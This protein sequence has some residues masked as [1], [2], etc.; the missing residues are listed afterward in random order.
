MRKIVQTVYN[1]ALTHRH[2]KCRPQKYPGGG[3]GFDFQPMALVT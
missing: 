3:E 2:K 1:G